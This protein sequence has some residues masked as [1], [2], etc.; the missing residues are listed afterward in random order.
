MKKMIAAALVGALCG[1]AHAQSS[2][3]LF[4]RIG[5]GV[6]W[7]NGLPGG[8]QVGFNNNIIA[9]NEFGIRGREDLGHGLK[10]L[11]V[12][13]NGEPKP[14]SDVAEWGQWFAANAQAR[15]VG[16]DQIGEARVSTVFLA[17]DHRHF[18]D[19]A[20]ILWETMVFDG[21]LDGEMDRYSNLEAAIEGHA[22]MCARVR[23]MVKLAGP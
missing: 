1:S 17:L 7:V 6:R 12:L 18:G 22:A 5:G 21:P 2:V 8:S 4:G 3:T 9:G 20:P 13:E 23:D 14:V 11:F 16:D 10:A 19:G 15:H